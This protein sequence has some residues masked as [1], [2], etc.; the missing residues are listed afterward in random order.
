MKSKQLLITLFVSLL[1][2]SYSS[3][4]GPKPEAPINSFTATSGIIGAIVM[5]KGTNLSTTASEKE[6]KFNGTTATVTASS[7]KR[8]GRF[9][10]E[11]NSN[12]PKKQKV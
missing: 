7:A 6:V 1:T 5:I 8:T 12:R 10:K 11:L 3:K 2:L 9:L 4:E